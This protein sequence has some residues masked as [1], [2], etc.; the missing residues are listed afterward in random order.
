[1][2]TMKSLIYLFSAAAMLVQGCSVK[3]DRGQCP[4]RFELDLSGIDTT[5]IKSVNVLAVI[6]EDVVFRDC[7]R[8]EDFSRGFVADVPHGDMCVNVWS[9]EDGEIEAGRL[10]RIPY[11]VE[12]PP[13][14]M[15]SFMADTRG[16]CV[17]VKVRLFKN[18]CRLSVRMQGQQSVPYSLT[19]KGGVDGYDMLGRPSSGDFSCVAYPGEDGASLALIPRQ[20]DSSLLLEVDDGRGPYKVFAVGEYLDAAGYDWSASDLEDVSLVLDYYKTSVKIIVAGWDKEYV[21][22]VI[23]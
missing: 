7:I 22:D 2:K 9:G 4:C 8:A 18:H 16:E 10:V 11:G 3:E 23:L 6:A 13:L 21:Y 15:H 14:Y 19:F 1:M 5:K 17:R 12:C 20:V